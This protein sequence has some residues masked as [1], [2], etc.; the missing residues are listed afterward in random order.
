MG[1][2]RHYSAE[3]EDYSVVVEFCRKR[4]TLDDGDRPDHQ[5][6]HNLV[7]RVLCL[8]GDSSLVDPATATAV[9]VV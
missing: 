1:R 3:R 2:V 7:L 9:A 6:H 8:S 5:Y 4:P